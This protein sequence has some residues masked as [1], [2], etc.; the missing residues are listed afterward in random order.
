MRIL[1]VLHHQFGDHPAIG[2]V[3]EHSTGQLTTIPAYELRIGRNLK[4]HSMADRV[5]FQ[6]VHES[7]IPGN[8]GRMTTRGQEVTSA[9]EQLLRHKSRLL[10]SGVVG[11][12][13]A[14]ALGVDRH[15]GRTNLDVTNYF[16][17]VYPVLDFTHDTARSSRL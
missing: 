9:C 5:R 1:D 15:L 13:V 3:N 14:A 17:Y 16:P 8:D 11:H 7:A 12:R 6:A 4:G 2:A 10:S